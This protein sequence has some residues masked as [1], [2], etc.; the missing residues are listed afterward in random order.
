MKPRGKGIIRRKLPGFPG[1]GAKNILG[2]FL[3]RGGITGFADSR[4]VHEVDMVV[5]ERGKGGLVATADKP[6]EQLKIHVSLIHHTLKLPPPEQI[7]NKNKGDLAAKM[8]IRHKITS[9]PQSA[10]L[11]RDL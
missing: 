10:E 4:A 11:R 7:R 5:N 3:G 1:Q 6:L 9:R 2:Y 8:R